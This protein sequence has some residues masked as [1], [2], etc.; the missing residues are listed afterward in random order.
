[1]IEKLVTEPTLKKITLRYLIAHAER[2]QLLKTS[3]NKKLRD[4]ASKKPFYEEFIAK[5]KEKLPNYTEEMLFKASEHMPQ[6][7][8]KI[9]LRCFKEISGIWNPFHYHELGRVIPTIQDGITT[10]VSTAANPKL[11]IM[12]S[13]GYC[14]NL[15]N[16]QEIVIEKNEKSISG[17]VEAIIQHY[18]LPSVE[19]PYL[20]MVTAS[21][22]Y[23]E[24]MPRLWGLPIHGETKITDI[25]IPLDE[26]I[27]SDYAYLGLDYEENEEDILV[28]GKII[29]RRI[30]LTQGIE[31]ALGYSPSKEYL[32]KNLNEFRPVKI[33]EDF[34]IDGDLIFPKGVRYG[35]PCNR[36]ELDIPYTDFVR[37]FWFT[38]KEINRMGKRKINQTEIFKEFKKSEIAKKYFNFMIEENNEQDYKI[39]VRMSPEAIMTDSLAIA[40]NAEVDKAIARAEAAEAREETLEAKANEAEARASEAELKLAFEEQVSKVNQQFGQ[41]RTLAH[42]NKNFEIAQQSDINTDYKEY[43]ENHFPSWIEIY[44]SA[45]SDTETSLFEGLESKII[46]V[47]TAPKKLILKTKRYLEMLNRS[48]KTEENSIMIMRGGGVPVK[49]EKL[50]LYEVIEPALD[51]VSKRHPNVTVLYQ[52]SKNIQ[53]EGDKRLL[54]AAFTNLIDNAAEASFPEG[55]VIIK[56]RNAK[57][58]NR[59]FTLIDISQTGHLPPEYAIN[60]SQGKHVDSTKEDGNA[61]GADASYNIITGPHR[62]SIN[63]KS[64]GDNG[65]RINIRL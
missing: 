18:M 1:M 60:L 44:H 16:D 31:K 56:A 42:D 38:L 49:I 29:G 47:N 63:Y 3:R 55:Q 14:R 26:L 8:F 9:I 7:D 61:V 23:S 39:L 54:R 64:L 40:Q 65:A 30:D 53:V 4:F 25:Q 36:Y 33:L 20:E 35:S 15:N 32:I 5:I 12:S 34:E 19:S 58:A 2:P 37:R 21:L 43:L 59:L 48:S 46:N 62:G 6:N 24:A 28:N 50:T 57:R 51:Y 11:A 52:P 13:P 17:K 10:L 27:K 45:L 41:I 22:G